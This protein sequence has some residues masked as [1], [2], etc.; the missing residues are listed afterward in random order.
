MKVFGVEDLTADGVRRLSA[1][2]KLRKR[3]CLIFGF[4]VFFIAV[5]CIRL[6]WVQFV[7]GDELRQ[8]AFAARFRNVE[9]KAKRGAIYDAKGRPLAISVSTDSFYAIPSQ[10]KNSGRAKEIAAQLAQ[11]LELEESFVLDRITRSQA[12]VWIQRH[13]PDEQAQQIKELKLPGI[14]FV[15]EPERFYPKGQLMANVLG[16]A[17]L[18]NQGLNGI[19]ISYDK[20]LSGKSGT[21]MVEYDNKGLEI[22]DAVKKYIPPEDGNS[23]Y[24][25]I[26]ETIQ[27]IVERELD[28]VMKTSTPKRAG[29]IVMEP[30]T[31][32]I[33]AMG[34]RPSFDPNNYN[35]YDSSLW[36]NFL[37]TD[38]Y[39][40]G[41][42]FKTAVAAAALEE[43]IV[44]PTERFYDPGYI[45]IGKERIRCWRHGRPHGSQTFA[46][47]V[48]NSCNPVFSAVGL[49]M[50]KETFYRYLDGFGFGKKTGISLP[51]EAI[52]IIVNKGR[53]Q[54]IDIASM[55]IGQ[56]NAVTPIQLISAFSAICNGGT[57]L[58]PQLVNEIRDNEGN[59][60]QSFKPEVVRQ[61]ISAETSKTVLEILES[62]V[63]DGTG[64]NAYVEGYRVGGKTGTAQK[65]IPG[66]GYSTTEFIA[67]V[68]AVAPVNDPKIAVLFIVDSP[69]GVHYG[70]TTAGPRVKNIIYD[71]L[72]YMKVEAQI[73]PEKI[74]NTEMPQM[75]TLPNFV[76]EDTQKAINEGKKLQLKVDVIGDGSKVKAQLPL[77]GTK[78][79]EGSK[80]V[81]YTSIP[82]TDG[83]TES[84]IV[85]DLT[86]RTIG[87]VKEI[88]NLLNLNF[89]LYGSGVVMRQEP[90]PNTQ[91]LVG[92]TI[93]IY[94]EP[95]AQAALEPISP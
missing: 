29:A 3:I 24:L 1:P 52:G 51:G 42:T 28:E 2:I 60:I 17:G 7:Q 77:A 16:F 39:E 68:I 44:T 74:S 10:V 20:I 82:T 61:V 84:V 46:E 9:V 13:V 91:L 55:S 4:S 31:G 75:V 34:V 43:G 72:R 8:K 90:E 6:V 66:I 21:I 58:K 89:E 18:D 71:T 62:V 92:S 80:L 94:M 14:L 93:K 78:V 37:V 25:T 53:A 67:S 81:I 40:P 85:P 59:V 69:V 38:V 12:F 54:D 87:E 47:G 63:S 15:E 22:P 88:T 65:V 83:K 64:Q 50:G 95:P 48:Q 11:I 73:E 49:R 57:Y 5:L 76:A 56:A 86:G 79:P 35:Q 36:R 45:Q 26:D 19:E 33:L 23:I 30:K 41:S 32:K 70:G 27:Y